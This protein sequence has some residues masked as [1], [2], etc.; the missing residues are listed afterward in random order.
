MCDCPLN[1][2][3]NTKK[4]NWNDTLKFVGELQRLF[5]KNVDLFP[6]TLNYRIYWK[7]MLYSFLLHKIKETIY[8]LY[9]SFM[10]IFISKGHAFWKIVSGVYLILR[11]NVP[12]P[13]EIIGFYWCAVKYNRYIK[14][15]IIFVNILSSMKSI[16]SVSKLWQ[17]KYILFPI[18][19]SNCCA[20]CIQEIIGIMKN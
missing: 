7:S 4:K 9:Q 8:I 3:Q 17:G 13:M 12:L 15:C 20:K 11:L 5:R 10:K 19:Q 6:P 1:L 18:F 14:N 2:G 16:K